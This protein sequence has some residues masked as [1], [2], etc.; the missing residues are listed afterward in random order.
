M[1]VCCGVVA[2]AEEAVDPS[3]PFVVPVVVEVPADAVTNVVSLTILVI[4]VL[5]IVDAVVDCVPAG[6]VIIDVE[7]GL[8][9]V[10]EVSERLDV[11]LVNDV[12]IAVD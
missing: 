8:D 12:S 11:P 10:K 6:V 3:D 4:D 5:L 7:P 9:E 2:V 1:L